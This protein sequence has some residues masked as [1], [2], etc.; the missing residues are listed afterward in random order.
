MTRTGRAALPMVLA[1]WC[2]FAWTVRADPLEA[3]V[4][5]FADP[6]TRATGG[7][8]LL[9]GAGFEVT[10]L[11]AGSFAEG[12]RA[13]VIVLG[14]F[15]SEDPDYARVMRRH[16]DRLAEWVA[17]GGVLVQMVQSARTE[18]RPPFLPKD[19]EARR[20]DVAWNLLRCDGTTSPLLDGLVLDHPDGP[21]FPLPG[22][23]LGVASQQTFTDLRGWTVLLWSD[24]QIPYRE[25]ALLEAA[26]GRGRILL[27]AIPLDK[28]T[29]SDGS[30]AVEDPYPLAAT[31]FAENLAAYTSSL[32]AGTLPTPVPTEA[33]T[34]APT[35]WTDG[36]WSIIVLPDTQFATAQAPEVLESQ[37]TWIVDSRTAR[38]IRFV[39]H[40][41]D[42]THTADR[43][44][45]RRARRAFDALDGVV[46]YAVTT[47]NHDYRRGHELAERSTDFTDF[48]GIDVARAQPTFGGALSVARP[49]N[50]FHTF[51]AGGRDWLL[52]TLEYLPSTDAVNW[53][54]EI[55]QGHPDH[56]VILVTHSY[57]DE[58]DGRIDLDVRLASLGHPPLPLQY[59]DGQDLWRSL[60]SRHANIRLVL[61]GHVTGDGAGR[62]TDVVDGRPVHQILANY[63]MRRDGGE[64]WLRVLEFLPDGRTLRVHTYSPWLDAFMTQPQHQFELELDGAPR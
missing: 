9:A 57:L 40:E 46:P 45:W 56:E 4:W 29:R 31:T 14:S 27:V 50:Q 30:P 1:I 22:H 47:G 24:P 63:Q 10:T 6:F 20:E 60:V 32:T 58:L 23:P 38:D 62:R 3:A 55:L 19:L 53:A 51:T 26:H 15:V 37:V 12:Y 64:G 39:V 16:A 48:F 2:L 8:A 11:T 7:A 18:P 13:D 28:L 44:E 5:E 52:L 35:G 25:A 41:G 36:S 61:C 43:R 34:P 17:D 59:H 49:E 33:R 54:E 42:V 21:R